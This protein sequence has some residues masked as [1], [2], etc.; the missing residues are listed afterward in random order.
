M[1]QATVTQ[2]QRRGQP[3]D[4]AAERLADAESLAHAHTPAADSASALTEPVGDGVPARDRDAAPDRDATAD[5]HA[6]IRVPDRHPVAR[7][8][9]EYV[10]NWLTEC[11]V[12]GGCP[13]LRSRKGPKMTGLSDT[14]VAELGAA[15]YAARHSG[16]P[17]EP[18]TDAYPAMSMRDAYLVQR[19][20]LAR[21]LA[22]GDRVVGYKL[23]LTLA[24][25]HVHG[26]IV[27]LP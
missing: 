7:P 11:P 1:G 18:L 20:L 4:R 6:D 17:I 24:G 23:G 5:R 21:L 16:V 14:S 13:R 15:L 9:C 22:D 2:R 12:V 19:D 10:G 3:G 8:H 25:S 27:L 26:K